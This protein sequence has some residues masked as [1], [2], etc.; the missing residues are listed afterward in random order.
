MTNSRAMRK[1]T[2]NTK[3]VS[4][5]QG[6]KQTSIAKKKDIAIKKKKFEEESYRETQSCV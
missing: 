4:F 6:L 2:R 3:K 5:A 1:S